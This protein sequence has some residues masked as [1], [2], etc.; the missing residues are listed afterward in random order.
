[1]AL[2]LG[3]VTVTEVFEFAREVLQVRYHILGLGLCDTGSTYWA[4]DSKGSSWDTSAWHVVLYTTGDFA[5]YF[6]AYR[7]L[8]TLPHKSSELNLRTSNIMDLSR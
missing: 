2:V 7:T 5:Y 6:S 3:A 8:R 1:M 4:I